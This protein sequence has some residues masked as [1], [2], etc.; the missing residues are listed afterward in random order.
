MNRMFGDLLQKGLSS[1][2]RTTLSVAR[3]FG[4]AHLPPQVGAILPAPAT[5]VC[6]ALQM[7]FHQEG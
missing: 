1:S 4:T 5:L 3:D 2:H 6:Q 7:R